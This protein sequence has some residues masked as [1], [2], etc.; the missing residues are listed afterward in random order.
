MRAKTNPVGLQQ[1]GA[2]DIE[3]TPTES[4]LIVVADATLTN[5]EKVI[6]IRDIL[7]GARAV[8]NIRTRF[9]VAQINA[10]A[11][12][13]PAVAGYKYR[14]TG[15]RAI[16]VGGAAGAVTTVD[17]LS[18]QA[19]A[20]VKLVAFAQASLTQSAVLKDGG[21]GAAVL[22]DGASYVANDSGA[23]VTVGKTGADVT[24]A[25]HIDVSVDYVLEK[26]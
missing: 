12:L 11:S 22:A 6:S 14:V 15:A 7:A 23:A 5:D 8:R 2:A 16:A 19:T 21:T 9:T 1:Y 3:T 17:L 13:L 25:T 10:G 24:V 26:A 18:T 20:S 4:D